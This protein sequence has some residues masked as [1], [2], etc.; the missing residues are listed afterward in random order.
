MNL[1]S[2]ILCLVKTVLQKASIA[3]LLTFSWQKINWDLAHISIQNYVIIIQ[4]YGFKRNIQTQGVF[5]KFGRK[6]LRLS[7]TK[8]YSVLLPHLYLLH[9]PRGEKKF[10]LLHGSA[11]LTNCRLAFW[12][13]IFIDL[14][15]M[16]HLTFRE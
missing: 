2:C 3:S 16:F 11:W 12:N 14:H 9:I 5:L 13:V 7:G 1:Y 15:L 6:N 4:L 10:I 8:D